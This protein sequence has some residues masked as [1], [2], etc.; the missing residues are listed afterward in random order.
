MNG[1]ILRDINT[2]DKLRKAHT[3][4]NWGWESD[5]LFR[6]LIRA[7]IF[8]INRL[9]TLRLKFSEN[10]IWLNINDSVGI[11]FQLDMLP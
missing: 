1:I 7:R 9:Y 10:I 8:H 3:E 11:I 6:L 4:G 5:R 2:S